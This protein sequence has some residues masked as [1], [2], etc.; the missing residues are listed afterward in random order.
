MDD[1]LFS[2]SVSLFFVSLRICWNGCYISWLWNETAEETN[3]FLFLHLSSSPTAELK[4]WKRLLY[5]VCFFR[6]HF[7]LPNASDESRNKRVSGREEDF[8]SNEVLLGS[9]PIKSS[10]A[11]GF[12]GVQREIKGPKRVFQWPSSCVQLDG[13][14]LIFLRYNSYLPTNGKYLHP[15]QG[16]LVL[17]CNKLWFRCKSSEI[18]IWQIKMSKPQESG[19]LLAITPSLAP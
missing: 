4:G 11:E 6:R 13:I 14:L 9:F 3:P 7:L 16:Q 5:C 19:Y 10:T 15:K 1:F 17:C 12:G 8:W 18:A 2:V